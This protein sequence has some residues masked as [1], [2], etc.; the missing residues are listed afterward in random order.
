MERVC[1]DFEAALKRGERPAI[2]EQLPLVPEGDRERLRADLLRLEEHYLNPAGCTEFPPM[3]IRFTVTAGA[4][5]GRSFAFSGHDTFL[6]GRS[7]HVHLRLP[8]SDRRCSRF[9]F[10]VEVNPPR[11]R[12]IDMG[13]HNGTFVNGQRVQTAELKHD[14]HVRAGRNVLRVSFGEEAGAPAPSPVVASAVPGPEPTA[15]L[16]PPSTHALSQGLSVAGL[17][18]ACRAALAAPAGSPGAVV[19]LCPGCQEQASRHAQMLSGYRIVRDLGRGGMGVVYLALRQED[20]LP[21]ALKTIIPATSPTQVQIACFLREASILRQLSHPHVVRFLGMG[22]AQGDL[23]ICM[24]YVAGSDARRLA[25]EGGPFAVS[26]AVTLMCQV[27]EALEYAHTRGFVHRDVKPSNILVSGVCGQ[28]TAKVA[29]FGLAR[30]YEAS[31]LSGLTLTGDVG[32][33]PAYQAPEQILHFREVRPA[34]DQYAA[35]ATLYYLLT[36]QH[37]LDLP[38]NPAERLR[39]VLESD[40]VPIQQRRP[41][42][43]EALAR[44]IHQALQRSPDRRHPNVTA[45]RAALEPFRRT[46]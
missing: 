40:A 14:D 13:S 8:S 4:H 6:V 22:Q 16:P 18:R 3:P 31:Q 19:L 7:R 34:A 1:D 32:G 45:L 37:I 23:F 5:K 30:V 11:C 24:E 44:I 15:H 12:L 39:T 41:D 10:L 42:V 35:A 27:L 9:H 21:V 36:A 26:R 20:G 33:T 2:E 25:R 17:C 28:E 46:A 29:D 38:A 43:P